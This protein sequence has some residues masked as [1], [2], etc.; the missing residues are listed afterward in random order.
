MWEAAPDDA[1]V[2][3]ALAVAVALQGRRD[4]AVRLWQRTV[5][6]D[7]RREE[8]LYVLAMHFLAARDIGE[9][10]SYLDRLIDVNPWRAELYGRQSE[11]FA[12]QGDFDLAQTAAE[13]ALELDPTILRAYAWL[14]V[15]HEKRGE[16]ELGEQIRQTGLRLEASRAT[17]RDVRKKP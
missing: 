10:R 9:A 2:A 12:T 8:A 6:L 14:A 15:L 16:P 5:E 4:E 7:P 17:A 3:G 13:K 11:L 1:D